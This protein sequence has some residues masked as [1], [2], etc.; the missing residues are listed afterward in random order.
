MSYGSAGEGRRE[1]SLLGE[2][3]NTVT[4]FT[5]CMS[6]PGFTWPVTCH[7]TSSPSSDI[8]VY[9]QHTYACVCVCVCVFVCL[10]AYFTI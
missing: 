10:F 7:M 4:L 3:S 1:E 8:T 6:L 2:C 9:A 5:T